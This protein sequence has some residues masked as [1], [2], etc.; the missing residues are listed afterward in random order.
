MMLV[1]EQ[2]RDR[3]ESHCFVGKPMQDDERVEYLFE[4]IHSMYKKKEGSPTD[5]KDRFLK[6]RQKVGESITEFAAELKDVLYQAWP[7]MPRDQLEELLVEYFVGG[8]QS[9]ET[10]AKVK[11]EKPKSIVKAIDIAE[12]YEDLLNNNTSIMTKAEYLTPQ[13]YSIFYRSRPTKV[14]QI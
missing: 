9:P 10:S 1:D 13:S 2:L 6:R 4:V 7:K 5:N 14:D 3:I 8:L 12:I 11:L